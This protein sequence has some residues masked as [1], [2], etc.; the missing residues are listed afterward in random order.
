MDNAPITFSFGENWQSYLKTVS[1]A[2]ILSA[3]QDIESWLGAATIKGKKILDIGCGSGI[4]SLVYFLLGAGELVS[5]DVD[6]KSVE[7]TAHLWK[8]AGKPAHWQVLQGSVL[9]EPF[10][11]SLGGEFDIAYAW[12]VLHHTGSIWQALDHSCRFLK[13]G[14]LLWVAIYTKGPNYPLHLA[15]KQRYNRASFLGKKIVVAKEIARLMQARWRNRMNP[16][17]WNQKRARGM[18]TYHD[19]IDWLGGLPYEVASPEEVEGF[20]T[21]RGFELKRVAVHQEGANSIYL[22]VRT[23]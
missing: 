7:A 22:F 16:F 10:V 21:P 23:G 6:P 15:L 18:D 11:E 8:Q 17:K 3:Q 2:S 1:Q 20:V 13:V 14:G 9:D 19:L 12:G 5:F 4:H